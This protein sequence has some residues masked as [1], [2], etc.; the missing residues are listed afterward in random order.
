[1]GMVLG[2]ALALALGDMSGIARY[3]SFYLPMDESLAYAG[4][5]VCGKPLTDALAFAALDISGRPYLEYNGRFQQEKVGEYDT[6]LTSEFFRALAFHAG[7]TLHARVE[8]NGNAHHAIEALFK[9]VAHALGEAVRPKN[10]TLSTKG[11]LD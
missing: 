1:V 2:D 7:I 10:G 3:G 8:E 6:C 9:A 4:V 5:D 11:S